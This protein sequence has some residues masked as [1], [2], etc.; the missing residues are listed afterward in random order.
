MKSST[1]SG[2]FVAP[3]NGQADAFIDGAPAGQVTVHG[4]APGAPKL[5]RAF[6]YFIPGHY[7]DGRSHVL[8][9]VLKD[10]TAIAFPTRGGVTRS[11]L[12]FR[13]SESEG[14]EALSIKPHAVA[15]PPSA[16]ET[17]LSDWVGLAAP[18]KDGTITGWAV[19]RRDPGEVVSLRFLVDG[20][21]A[22]E[23]ICD[24]PH[25]GLRALGLPGGPGGF[26]YTLPGRL[27][28]GP[29]HA[30]TILLPDGSNLP[31]LNGD[32]T[33]AELLFAADGANSIEG[34]VEGLHGSSICGWVVRRHHWTGEVSGC[35]Q[36]QVLCN[37]IVI[38][39][40][41]ADQ[42]RTDV[43]RDRGCTPHIGFEFTLPAHLTASREV[44]L[45]FKALPEGLDLPGCPVLVKSRLSDSADD[46][47]A[48]SDSIGE[49]C[50]GIFKLQQK[51]RAMLPVAEA[52]VLNY[53]RWA[54]QYLERLSIRNA[55]AEP[56]PRD[57]PLVTVVMNI[58]G[59]RLAHLT[60]SVSS[61][62]KQT[63]SNWE[64]ILVHREDHGPALNAWK[65]E[66]GS[67]DAR[68]TNLAVKAGHRG[69]D[70][71]LRRARGAYVLLFHHDA[72][73]VAEALD[74]L[75]REAVRSEAKVL[76]SD[77]DQIDK[78]GVFG[79][80]NLKPDWNYRLMLST[81]YIGQFIMAETVLMRSFGVSRA[82]AQ[83]V[84]YHERLLRLS[85]Q[86]QPEQITHVSEILFHQRKG[87]GFE[88]MST[89]AVAA[90]RRAVAAHLARRGFKHCE[91]LPIGKGT[92]YKVLWGLAAQPSVT[93]IVPFKDQIAATRRCVEALLANTV[94]T[95]WRIVLVDDGSVTPEAKAF[96]HD[97]LNNPRIVV[98]RVEEPFNYSRLNNIAAREFPADWYVFLNNDVFLAQSDWLRVLMDE[99][100]ADPMAA[101]VGAKLVYPDGTVQHGGVVLGV[102]G[103]ADHAFRSFP[104]DH[105]GYQRR[106]R[107]AQQY[108]AV[109]AACMLCREKAFTEVG[110]FDEEHLAVAFND[111]DLCLKVTQ[112]GWHVIWS[113][114]VVAEHGESLSRGD[115]LSG[116]KAERFF[117][118]Y[119]YMLERWGKILSNDPF[120]NRNFSRFG[121]LFTDLSVPPSP[122]LGDGAW[123]CCSSRI[124]EPSRQ[125]PGDG[126]HDRVGPRP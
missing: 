23:T 56:L 90:G 79:E 82:V 62:R 61:V 116:R 67:R 100:L 55:A 34:F 95:E 81:N 126:A 54:R 32:G 106:A 77:E 125:H 118:E 120:Y 9:L 70:L 68:I 2:W 110:G 18:P 7:Q 33:T 30:I 92:S 121:R 94:W 46:L 21:S 36:T 111:V 114:D 75:V 17:S 57:P 50:T 12:R 48:I 47:R 16:F 96:C 22:G 109:T 78:H 101:I 39:E 91:V 27:L 65:S 102:D 38:D 64:L 3:G 28:G 60:S 43:A 15:R 53:D 76:Y 58:D 124:E 73:M 119:H 80:P 42:L 83:V 103:I 71:A 108:S 10:G 31:F 89:A 8:S 13:F 112:R 44:E 72:L 51:M 113:P 41:T 117:Y 98:R 59:T 97:A 6:T 5:A 14:S 69:V 66:T 35:V 19:Y 11:N 84:Q 40:I 37:G 25:D 104:A 4:A 88:K 105:P 85:E 74:V 49:L 52:T 26:T 63:Y 29:T 123:G 24:Q 1:I 99:A 107:C 87:D 20:H 86:C 45:V 122:S 93:I 115:D